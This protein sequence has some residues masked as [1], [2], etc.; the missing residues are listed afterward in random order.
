MHAHETRTRARARNYLL[1]LLKFI[2]PIPKRS[3]IY[4]NLAVG[5]SINNLKFNKILDY[6]TAYKTAF[7]EK[8]GKP[9][10]E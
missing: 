1:N 8:A 5:L 3:L 2:T 7:R 6:T 10:T 4:L 9:K